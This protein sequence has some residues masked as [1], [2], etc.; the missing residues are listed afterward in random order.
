[1]NGAAFVVAECCEYVEV[2]PTG[3]YGRYS[4]ILGKG[5]SKTVYRAFDEYEG[6][7]VA[8]NQVKFYDFLQNPEDLERLYSE[9]HLLKTLKHKNI[10]KFYTSWVDTT[11]R[12]INFVTEMFTSG[13][14]RQYR[15]KHKRVNIRA[16]KHWCR[17]I[18]EGLL[19][20]HS[21]D[22]PVIHRDLKCDNIF[23]NGNQGEVKI[24]DLGLAAI[25][26]KSNAARC[27]GTPEF[28]APEVYEEDYNEL[29]DIYSFGM[30]ILEMVT[31]EYPYSECNHP[32]QIY[33]KVVSGKK[34]EAL[35]KVDNT[36]VRQFVEKCLA[37][38]SLRLSARELLDDPFLQIYDYGFDSKV[39]Q[40]HRDCYEVNPLIR[41][42]LNGIY[43]INN[44]LMSGDTDN[45]GGYGPV[46]KLD[47]HRDDFEASEIGLF[48]CE[49]DDNLAE[50]DTT[51]KGR[52]EDDGIFL[53]LRI[54]DKEGR[55][56]NIYFP[57]DIET[58]TALSVANE[59]VAELD[60][61]DQDVTNLANMIDN[62]IATLV[63]EWKTGPIIEE[64]S[65]CSSASVC[66]NCAANGYL[67]DY[68]LSN[69]PCGKNLQFLHCSKTGCAAVHGRF[70]EITYQVEGSKNSAREAHEASNSSNIKEDGKTINVDEQ[71]DLNTR[72]PSSNPAPNCVFLDYENEIRQ[73][74]RWL[75]AKYQMQL[76]EL[77]DQQLGGKPK[78][79]S[80]SPD[81]DKLEHLKDGILRLSDAS[82]LKIQNNKPLLKTIDFFT[83]VL[84]PHSLQRATSLPVDA[85]DV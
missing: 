66:L 28:M 47:Y 69:N 76:R 25:L 73:E 38:V 23:I 5:A 6:I 70:E 78:F 81:T 48:G 43:S 45:V 85:V 27:V 35:Y 72:K 18:L 1:M 30:C 82:N 19:Y 20:L 79:T 3:R 34:P 12:H 54:A 22:P 8:W 7:E 31:F 10:M 59:M 77:R 4:E 39:V 80:I 36:E 24:G 63:P 65:E 75:K 52:R 32:A 29:V 11:N 61:N 2:D 53:R 68:V 17:Q 21:H 42:P 16:V 83:G 44:N 56:R 33:K 57:F 58:D 46:S 9:I 41:Q 26:R 49:E 50:V 13:T 51:I 67:F 15:L 74:L 40:Y 84:L 55:I 71:S 62:E 60:I 64:K 14:L 37:T